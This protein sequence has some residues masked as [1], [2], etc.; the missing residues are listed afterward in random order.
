[1][2]F[3]RPSHPDIEVRT[4]HAGGYGTF[5]GLPP[6]RVRGRRP[7]RLQPWVSTRTS[8]RGVPPRSS[9]PRRHGPHQPGEHRLAQA[10]VC[11]QDPP[12]PGHDPAARRCGAR[13]RPT[14]RRADGGVPE[15]RTVAED[16]RRDLERA[17]ATP[18]SRSSDGSLGPCAHSTARS[19]VF[20]SSLDFRATSRRV[21]GISR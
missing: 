5:F 10:V 1:M 14:G 21:C 16:R 6:G 13:S 19:R 3:R 12:E 15:R 11:R 20:T 9:R 8:G 2:T 18:A 7:A 17:A 4:D